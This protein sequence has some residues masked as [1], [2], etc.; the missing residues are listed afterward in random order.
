MVS[1]P[2]SEAM[3]FPKVLSDLPHD[4]FWSTY[5]DSFH[6]FGFGSP[7]NIIMPNFVTSQGGWEMDESKEDAARRETIEEAGVDGK[8][9]VSFFRTNLLSIPLKICCQHLF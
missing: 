7:F 1:S 9:Q 8:V 4:S 5:T 3:M 6:V 2:K